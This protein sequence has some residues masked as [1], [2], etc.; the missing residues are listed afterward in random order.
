VHRR[1]VAQTQGRH[2]IVAVDRDEDVA[3]E[4]QRLDG[5]DSG[6]VVFTYAALDAF[7]AG[8]A[9][10]KSVKAVATESEAAE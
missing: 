2:V 6:Q 7:L 3:V 1:D 5:L 4:A 9:S 10:G 8:P